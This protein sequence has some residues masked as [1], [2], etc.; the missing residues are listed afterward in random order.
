[1]DLMSFFS[2]KPASQN[3]WLPFHITFNGKNRKFH[4]ISLK[5]WWYTSEIRW[6]DM[7]RFKGPW[8][9]WRHL[10]AQ[11]GPGRGI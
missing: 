3:Q 1:M 2:Q 4:E 6:I 11:D 10:V 5:Q 8:A 7:V 9:K